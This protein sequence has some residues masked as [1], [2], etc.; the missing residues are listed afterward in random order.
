MRREGGQ[1]GCK[2]VVEKRNCIHL[3]KEEEEKNEEKWN[4]TKETGKFIAKSHCDDDKNKN[5]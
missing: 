2:V 5:K 1:W 3:T 4:K